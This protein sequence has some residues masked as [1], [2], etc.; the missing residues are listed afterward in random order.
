MGI[1]RDAY[2]HFRVNPKKK[3]IKIKIKKRKEKKGRKVPES[4]I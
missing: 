1:F 4:G 2:S 3:K